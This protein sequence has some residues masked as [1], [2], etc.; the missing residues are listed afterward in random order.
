MKAFRVMGRTLKAAYDDLF[1]C[2][3]LSL[4]W[5]V[6]TFLV[7]TAAPVTVGIH[8]VANRIANYR[9]V[10]NGFFWEAIRQ[11]IGRGWLLFLINLL[12]PVAILFNIWF[13]FNSRGWLSVIGVAWAWLLVLCLMI[14]QYLF[15]LL[16]QQDTPDLRLAL[17]NAA[18]LTLRHPLYSFLMM[19]FQLVLLAASAALTLPLVLLAPAL[20][21]LAGNFALAGLLQEMGL[22][23]PPP[24]APVRGA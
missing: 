13:Y 4:A 17:R 5:W 15:P 24:E 16:W 8:H 11:N 2:V 18:L 22:A 7:V 10:D 3:F 23:P 12:V 1:L 6:G 20:I 21:A 14:G 19:I 9:R